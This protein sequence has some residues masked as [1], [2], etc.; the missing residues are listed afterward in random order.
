MPARP[1]CLAPRLWR[2]AAV[3]LVCVFFSGPAL[4]QKTVVRLGHFPNVTHAQALV[5]HALS[6]QG[7][8]WFEQRLGPGVE[9]QW[10]VYNAGPSATEA[11]FADAIDATYVGPSPAL[12]AYFR[13]RGDEIRILAG[14][15][16]G[17][18]ALVVRG[19]IIRSREDFRGRRFATPQLGNTQDV[20]FRAWLKKQGYRV[21][22]TGGDVRLVPAANP[23]Q[24][25]LFSRGEIDGAWTVEPWVSR[26]ELEAN[27]KIFLEQKDTVTTVLVSSAKFLKERGELA[28]GLAQ[29]HRE[30]TDW[31]RAHPAEAKALAR[32]ELTALA[33]RDMPAPLLERSWSRLRFT[34]AVSRASLEEFVKDAREAGF[35]R[36]AVDL[37]RLLE[38]AR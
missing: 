25:L 34:D 24:L 10:F 17:G 16:E 8:G 38:H 6:R 36:D 3:L 12:N 21:T 5:A 18:A 9:I 14:A 23:D 11:I 31:I 7:K 20:E 30:L 19:E 33:R 29:A 22:Q 2:L 26:L 35:I 1:P 4:A 32:A 15:V 28:R 37:G 13:S 27:G